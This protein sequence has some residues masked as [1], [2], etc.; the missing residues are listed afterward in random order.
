VTKTTSIDVSQKLQIAAETSDKINVAR[1]EFRPVAT[2]GSILYFLIVEMSMVN[3]MYQTSLKQFLQLFDMS[4]D[5]SPKSPITTKR[6]Q[7]IVEYMTYEVYKYSVRGFYEEHKFMFTL[8]LAL[9]I[10]MQSGRVRHEEFQTLI[11][12]G[13]SL[14]LNVV[15][16]KPCKWV[17]DSTWLNLVEL[18][19]L[20]Q[21]SAILEQIARNEKQWK[22]WYDKEAPEDEIIP[23]GY[24]TS[25]DVFR[26]LLLVRSWCPDR[27]LPQAKKYIADSIGE[28]YIEGVILDLEKMCEESDPRTPLICF[29]SMGSDPTNLI[30]QLAK[31]KS[32]EIKAISMGQ[33]Q[34][35]HARRLMSNAM[36]NG[37][38]LLLQNCHLS[39]EF[40][41][42]VLDTLIANEQLNEHFRLWITTEGHSKFPIGLLQISIKYTAEPPQGIKAGLKRTFQA[43]SG[44]FLDV[45]NLPYWKPM[46]F[47]VA[48]LHTIVQERRKFGP[49][50]WNIPYE[51]NQSDFNATVQ[52]V[53]NH[54]DELDPKRVRLSFSLSLSP[55]LRKKVKF[56]SSKINLIN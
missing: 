49:L 29:L 20:Y 55:S 25:L 24:N 40:C 3:I 45:S 17:T 33:G 6:I 30:E 34:E 39:L 47:G 18:S 56:V 23:D 10:D 52:F 48:F 7:N 12:G 2:R 22:Q 46:L 14:D 51:F 4:M 54:L 16:P 42:E 35:L 19:K 32:I 27:A 26:K 9:K 8:L 50:G 38:W 13:A 11:K 53:Q 36:A 31:R 5:R 1:E 21:F 41:D 44:D 15:Q 43:L 28:K 37:G